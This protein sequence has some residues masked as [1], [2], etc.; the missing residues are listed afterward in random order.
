[1]SNAKRNP[2]ALG[3][4]DS[5]NLRCV[6]VAMGRPPS[7]KRGAGTGRNFWGAHASP[8]AISGVPAGKPVR[9]DAEHHTRGAY[10]PRPSDLFSA[11]RALQIPSLR[12]LPSILI[13]LAKNEC[14]IS[15]ESAGHDWAGRRQFAGSVRAEL[16]RQSENPVRK[17]ER[18]F[19]EY[20]PKL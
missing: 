14:G 9:R 12:W 19:R 15:E 6:C 18:V 11:P 2:Q 3:T 20:R 7:R 13:I 4:S 1:V 16:N 8:R 10:A 17:S 5:T